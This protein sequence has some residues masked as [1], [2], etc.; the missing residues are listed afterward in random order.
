[1]NLNRLFR[2]FNIQRKLIIAFVLLSTIPVCV[3][4]FYEIDSRLKT[5][6]GCNFL[7]V[8]SI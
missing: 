8:N 2:Q 4:G 6:G 1:M 5:L 3:I 7:S